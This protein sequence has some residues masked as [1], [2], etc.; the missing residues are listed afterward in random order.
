MR[1]VPVE[2][3]HPLLLGILE[4]FSSYCRERGLTYFLDYGT[5][6]GAVRHRGF[7]PWD[8]D[9]DV[10]MRR[11]DYE[12]LIGFAKKDP[13]IDTERRYRILLPVEL[14]NFYPFIKVVDERTLAYERN[15][16]HEYGLGIWLDVFC[17]GFCPADDGETAK[18]FSRHNRLKQMNKMLVCGDIIDDKYKRIYPIACLVSTILKIFGYTTERC[19]GEIIDMINHLPHSGTRVAQLSWPDNINKDSS[20]A[21]WWIDSTQIEFEGKLFSAPAMYHEVLT[22]HYGDY[23]TLPPEKE[24][25]RHG[26]EA[27]YLDD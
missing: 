1:R 25:V 13:Y 8:D 10:S 20:P 21:S 15:I 18:L 6:L 3:I 11:D 7:I 22:K 4:A 12:R 17:I 14:P 23:M 9:V 5:L 2:D 19:M 26:F 27:Y 16:R 24:R